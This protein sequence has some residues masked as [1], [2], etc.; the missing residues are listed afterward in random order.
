LPEPNE[1]KRGTDNIE[2]PEVKKTI[3]YKIIILGVSGYLTVLVLMIVGMVFFLKPDVTPVVSVQGVVNTTPVPINSTQNGEVNDPDINKSV[4]VLLDEAESIDISDIVNELKGIEYNRNLRDK[5]EQDSVARLLAERQT[6]IAQARLE[7]LKIETAKLISAR[8]KS[9]DMVTEP[10]TIQTTQTTELV[11][12][13][14]KDGFIQLAKIYSAM[15]PT[16]AAKILDK[17]ET[18]L[19]VNLLSNM[20]NRNAAKILSSF[21]PKKAARISKKISDNFAQN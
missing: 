14:L 12:V 9:I 11:K 21:A 15:K 5:M 2:I 10:E 8:P 7:A 17:M 18:N 20:K 13:E 1:I 16:D 6:K 4:E 19:V 3:S